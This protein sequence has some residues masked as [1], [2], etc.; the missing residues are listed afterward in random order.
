MAPTN[1]D[2]AVRQL[3][4]RFGRRDRRPLESRT[5]DTIPMHTRDV[6]W[7]EKDIAATPA[8][9][10]NDK[11]LESLGIDLAALKIAHNVRAAENCHPNRMGDTTPKKSMRGT[12]QKASGGVVEV[13]SCTPARPPRCLGESAVEDR[14]ASKLLDD[15]RR[16]PKRTPGKGRRQSSRVSSRELRAMMEGNGLEM[17]SSPRASAGNGRV[18]RTQAGRSASFTAAGTVDSKARFAGA[19]FENAG[20]EV[21]LTPMRASRQQREA[22]GADH[23]MTP[24]RRSRRKS[25]LATV[26]V[27]LAALEIPDSKQNLL[28][29]CEYAFAPNPMIV[30]ADPLSSVRRTLL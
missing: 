21:V 2:G 5:R 19:G 18:P 10:D 23:V 28:E 13:G 16:A 26:P 3:F 12:A 15:M 4:G 11:W 22:L 17:V 30:N 1:A 14:A 8:K 29:S 25:T 24:V 27:N 7:Q 9:E 6:Q 20:T